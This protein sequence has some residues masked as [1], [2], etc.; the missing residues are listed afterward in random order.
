MPG[1]R[2]AAATCCAPRKCRRTAPHSY[3]IIAPGERDGATH[4]GRRRSSRSRARTSHR[5]SLGV[6]GRYI[7]QPEVMQILD[8]G[9]NRRRRRDSAHGRDGAADRQAAFP[10]HDGRRRP[11]RLRRQGRLRHCQY[12]A[13]TGARGHRPAIREFIDGRSLADHLLQAASS[14]WLSIHRSRISPSSIARP[15]TRASSVAFR[16]AASRA[17]GT[18]RSR[19]AMRAIEHLEMERLGD[20]RV[21]ALL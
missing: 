19:G 2:S 5:R 17:T 16:R 1:R 20:D 10:R 15:T 3:G 7:L 13:G 6:I 21:G 14:A 9:R 8:K 4:R 11:L 18:A 12:G